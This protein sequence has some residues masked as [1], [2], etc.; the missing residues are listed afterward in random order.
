MLVCTYYTLAFPMCMCIHNINVNRTHCNIFLGNVSKR[1]A[2]REALHSIED[3][4]R[5][6]SIFV[7]H[8][9]GARLGHAIPIQQNTDA[10][11]VAFHPPAHAQP[12]RNRRYPLRDTMATHIKEKH[13]SSN[14]FGESSSK[15]I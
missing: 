8:N 4:G 11:C 7:L 14:N 6:T 13:R 9:L 5:R 15:C 10:E 2:N 3:H 12:Y 1:S